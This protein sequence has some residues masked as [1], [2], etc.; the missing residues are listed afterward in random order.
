MVKLRIDRN[1][2]PQEKG[3]ILLSQ[4]IVSKEIP[5]LTGDWEFVIA[6]PA[7]RS[8]SEANF[9]WYRY[10]LLKPAKSADA[11]KVREIVEERRRDV[12]ERTMNS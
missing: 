8:G 1:G 5:E 4:D 7:F 10:A 9:G 12:A 3:D 6:K 2:T 11:E